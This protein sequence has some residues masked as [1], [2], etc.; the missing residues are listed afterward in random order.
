MRKLRKQ[1]KH[2]TTGAAVSALSLAAFGAIA[3]ANADSNPYVTIDLDYENPV[4]VTTDEYAFDADSMTLELKEG[5]SF[6]LDEGCSDL[7]VFNYGTILGNLEGEEIIAKLIYNYGTISDGRYW[8]NIENYGTLSGGVYGY[9]DCSYSLT[10]YEKGEILGGAYYIPIALAGR[11][12]MP[13]SNYYDENNRIGMVPVYIFENGY[14]ESGDCDGY[15]DIRKAKR[16][17]PVG[18]DVRCI[19][20]TEEDD[21]NVILVTEPSGNCLYND[22][23]MGG[24]K[25]IMEEG[26]YVQLEGGAPVFKNPV[27]NGS[28][29]TYHTEVTF[30]G[31][32]VEIG[33]KGMLGTRS[34]YFFNGGAEERMTV[35]IDGQ[36]M[37]DE[38]ITFTNCDVVVNGQFLCNADIILNNSTLT[39]NGN[40]FFYLD[41]QKIIKNEGSTVDGSYGC[42]TFYMDGVEIPLKSADLYEGSKQTLV[43]DGSD[44]NCAS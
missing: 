28:F 27:I 19:L 23:V 37:S 31:K 1:L 11:I 8:G 5:Y 35:T 38:D 21:E 32:S 14:F 29:N 12:S 7:F 18:D 15:I 9:Y 39:T 26:S 42:V 24:A 44:A 22:N 34:T 10:C 13:V 20:L 43:M 30:T 3:V 16:E 4:S 17:T 40:L 6:M 36:I 25:L 41:D 33:E 2:L